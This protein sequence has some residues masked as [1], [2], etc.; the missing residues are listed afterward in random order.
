[1]NCKK[2]TTTIIQQVICLLDNIEDHKYCKPL[3]I[4][5][6]AFLGKHFR[7]IFDFY[8]CLLNGIHT[9][10]VNYSNRAR[11]AEIEMNTNT[12]SEAFEE[13]IKQIEN[14]NENM[15]IKV[16]ADFGET[17]H[18]DRV[19]VLSSVGRELM[20]AYDHAVHHLAMIKIA[21]KSNFPEIHCEESL[22]LAPATLRYEQEK[23]LLKI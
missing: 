13:I 21:L 23:T 2:G 6:G 14:V 16:K 1:M 10:L 9:G 22:G 8:T 15:R 5:E 4:F 7:H 11:N 19:L 20:Y 17:D 12:A 18:E 3:A